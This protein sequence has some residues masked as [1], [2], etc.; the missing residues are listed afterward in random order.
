MPLGLVLFGV[1]APLLL[2]LQIG[3]SRL[4]NH[5]YT[6]PSEN[7]P[8][9]STTTSCS[10]FNLTA[11]KTCVHTKDNDHPGP[12]VP[13]GLTDR[14]CH[15]AFV[16][17]S[18]PSSSSRQRLQHPVDIITSN[19]PS[20]TST[21]STI[22]SKKRKPDSNSSFPRFRTTVTFFFE[23]REDVVRGARNFYSW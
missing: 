11:N 8:E 12:L 3:D 6:N 7:I 18:I 20:T 4:K 2:Q 14:Q 22:P 16:F 17:N 5:Q 21:A 10:S 15:S 19:S 23:W 13:L 1:K 9:A